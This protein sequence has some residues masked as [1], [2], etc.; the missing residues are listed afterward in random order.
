MIKFK[1]NSEPDIT[2]ENLNKMQ[3]D[4][5]TVVSATEP[6][7]DERLKV[8]IKKGKNLFDKNNVINGYRLGSDGANFAD[9]NYSVSRYI[10]VNSNTKYTANW[11][12]AVVQCI[13]YYNENKE[14]ISRNSTEKTF[15]T[16]SN[17]KYIK[18]SR[19]TTDIGTTQIEQGESSTSYEAYIEPEIYVLNSNG[20]YEEL[21]KKEDISN[22]LYYKSGDKF[23]TSYG[24]YY[25][26]TLTGSLKTI[27]FTIPFP[28]ST[29][30]IKN[31]TINSIKITVRDVKGQYLLNGATKDTFNGN[32]T[33]E[34]R[35]DY[36]YTIYL[37]SNTAFE[38]INNTPV[39]VALDSINLNFN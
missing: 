18:A 15:L 13:C 9:A 38:S 24:T 35:T 5:G 20:V 3:Q 11:E 19:L 27:S 36:L 23:I 16:P 1:N 30:N 7:G 33:I 22:E 28:K 17:C 39:A 29:K 4:I 2:D 21:M 25:G 8:W 6:Q 37:S 10:P 14:F 26:G 12:I 32:F 34:K 31:I